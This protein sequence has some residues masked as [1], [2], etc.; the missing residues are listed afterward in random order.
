MANTTAPTSH[1]GLTRLPPE[2][3]QQIASY[4]YATH[5]PNKA[6]YD[7]NYK[8]PVSLLDLAATSKSL[9]T[10]VND[11][12]HHI[13]H[14]HRSITKYKDFKTP[15]AADKQRPLKFLL[16][17]TSKSCV[18]CGKKS[19]RS[20]I[21][22]NG[23]RCCRTCDRDQWP[24]K[25]TKSAALKEYHMKEHQLLPDRHQAFKLLTRYPGLPAPRYGTYYSMG[26]LTTIFLRKD[27]KALAELA[28]GDL[29]GHLGKREEA[30]KE[31]ARKKREAAEKKRKAIVVIDEDDETP[32]L[33]EFE[34]PHDGE[35]ETVVIEDDEEQFDG[36]S[37]LDSDP[38]FEQLVTVDDE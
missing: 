11:W 5:V 14:Q 31:R 8:P 21:L 18:F 26:V 33:E 12:A 24:D 4:L 35:R 15:A 3:I 38:L 20:A 30:R 13:L 7:T 36:S 19:V 23:L 16:N 37:E 25:I 17:W 27:V 22:M 34:N 2:I 9:N 32:E 10:Q 6:Y 29:R 28:H 1:D